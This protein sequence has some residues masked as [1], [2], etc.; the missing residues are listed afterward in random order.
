[1]EKIILK[2]DRTTG[3]RYLKFARN[4]LRLL[5]L[6]NA[7]SEQF[8]YSKVFKVG[9]S[10][11]GIKSINGTDIIYINTPP[12]EKDVVNQYVQEL[13]MLEAYVFLGQHTWGLG[14]SVVTD[15]GGDITLS[16]LPE[17][18]GEFRT[19]IQASGS[20]G[21]GDKNV[22]YAFMW[23]GSVSTDKDKVIKFNIQNTGSNYLFFGVDRWN[24]DGT[25][26]ER[27]VNP[28]GYTS[29]VGQAT[30]NYLWLV[31]DFTNNIIHLQPVQE[32]DTTVGGG[33]VVTSGFFIEGYTYSPVFEA[34]SYYDGLFESWV[35]MKSIVAFPELS[36][37]PND[38]NSNFSETTYIW[39]SWF[40]L[41]R[42]YSTDRTTRPRFGEGII[43]P[44]L[45][46][47]GELNG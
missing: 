33:A 3:K 24:P 23:E 16:I 31:F 10:V 14:N 37:I 43:L 4:K 21:S 47:N 20:V 27:Y 1:M 44:I 40:G 6:A 17:L 32:D 19:S 29:L 7:G 28:E 12:D 42:H 45:T 15:P 25:L 11:I 35:L 39:D 22:Q 18:N 34:N 38:L 2:G 36:I 9:R 41:D 13:P 8:F 26:H 46:L 30:S 5:R